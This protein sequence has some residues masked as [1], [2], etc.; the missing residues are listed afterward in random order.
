MKFALS[1]TF[2]IVAFLVSAVDFV[3]SVRILPDLW[4]LFVFQVVL[5]ASEI[6]APFY[7]RHLIAKDGHNVV[8]DTDRND[9]PGLRAIFGIVLLGAALSMLLAGALLHSTIY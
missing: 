9:G 7:I 5:L 4:L 2:L 8:G 6:S 1:W 3:L